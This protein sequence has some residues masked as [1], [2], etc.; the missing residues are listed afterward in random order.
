MKAIQTKQKSEITR[1]I[2]C[3]I[4]S[5]VATLVMV[6]TM[7]PTPEEYT[8]IASNLISV[9]PILADKFGCGYVSIIIGLWVDM[10]MCVNN[11]YGVDVCVHVY[12]GGGGGGGLFLR[13]NVF[14]CNIDHLEEQTKGKI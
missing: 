6:H 14:P 8:V 2:R 3:E 5:S 12:W 7:Y 9:H 10:I 11:W 13:V 1:A 4:I